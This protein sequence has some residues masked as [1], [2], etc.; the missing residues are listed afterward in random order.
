M[1]P[2][3]RTTTMRMLSFNMRFKAMLGVPQKVHQVGL[4][5]RRAH[6]HARGRARGRRGCGR[7]R[8]GLGRGILARGVRGRALE[9]LVRG[10]RGH[11]RGLLARGARGLERGLRVRVI[12]RAEAVGVDVVLV[13]DLLQLRLGEAHGLSVLVRVLWVCPMERQGG[14]WGGQERGMRELGPRAHARVNGA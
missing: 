7:G 2:P 1:R 14:E 11:G 5:L 3:T 8:R 9:L 4:A 10:A 13:V 6:G 12:V